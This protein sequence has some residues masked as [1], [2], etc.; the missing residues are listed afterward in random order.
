MSPSER[1]ERAFQHSAL[2]RSF[3]EGVLRQ[4][5]PE[6]GEREIM[7]RAANQRL[8][9]KLFRKAFANELPDDGPASGRD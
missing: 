4:Q 7:L 8:G 2:V 5:H 9:P 1:L 3:A 6:A